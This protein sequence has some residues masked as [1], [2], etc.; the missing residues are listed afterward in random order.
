MRWA[1]ACIHTYLWLC[2]CVCC[3]SEQCVAAFAVAQCDYLVRVL[4]ILWMW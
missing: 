1:C 4:Y 2:K 3:D